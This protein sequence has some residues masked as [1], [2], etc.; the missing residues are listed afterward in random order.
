MIQMKKG[1][2]RR[3]FYLYLFQPRGLPQFGQKR[4]VS[5]ILPQVQFHA[6]MGSGRLVPQLMQYFPVSPDAPH[7]QLHSVGCPGYIPICC[8]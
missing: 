4:D 2:L 6:P 7:V 8:P 3:P 5:P 1:T